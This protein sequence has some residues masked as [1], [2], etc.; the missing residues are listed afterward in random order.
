MHF[1]TLK[2]SFDTLEDQQLDQKN[3]FFCMGNVQVMCMHV[4][5]VSLGL[6][7]QQPWCLAM[8]QLLPHLQFQESALDPSIDNLLHRW[9]SP[10][11]CVTA[12]KD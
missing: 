11:V 6:N 5:T 7:L 4:L 8:L 10:I 9:S 1:Q 2:L 12:L 3:V